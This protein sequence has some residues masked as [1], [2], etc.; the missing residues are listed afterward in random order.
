MTQAK[1]RFKSHEFFAVPFID[2]FP[3]HLKD[4]LMSES[5]NQAIEDMVVNNYSWFQSLFLM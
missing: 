5:S 2:S 1:E 3:N 4:P